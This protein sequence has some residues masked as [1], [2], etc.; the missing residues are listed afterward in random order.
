MS[1]MLKIIRTIFKQKTGKKKKSPC[2]WRTRIVVMGMAVE[3]QEP[4][5]N[6]KF[7]TQLQVTQVTW[8]H[9]CSQ[10]HLRLNQQKILGWSTHS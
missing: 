9:L 8:L 5:P 6:A 7:Y 3:A 4:E 1:C 2:V 10:Y